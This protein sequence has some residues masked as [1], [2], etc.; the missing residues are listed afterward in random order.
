MATITPLGFELPTSEDYV[1]IEV[2][3]QNFT[4]AEQEFMKRPELDTGTGKLKDSD[5]PEDVS[6]AVTH[7]KITQGNPHGTKAADIFYTDDGSLAVT[8]VQAAVETLLQKANAI[9]TDLSNEI[10]SLDARVSLLELI[11]ATD[12]TQNPFSVTFA[13]L[14]GITASGVWNVTNRRMEF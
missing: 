12:V 4:V 14:D 13:T 11:L 3:S 1:E 8:N 7:S 9:D 10:T 5:M 6:G 2:I